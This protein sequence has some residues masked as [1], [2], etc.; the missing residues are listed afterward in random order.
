MQ[1]PI[2]G[3]VGG[4]GRIG[5][6]ESLWRTVGDLTNGDPWKFSK[7]TSGGCLHSWQV[8][9]ASPPSLCSSKPE[10]CWESHVTDKEEVD[11]HLRSVPPMEWGRKWPR[12]CIR[13]EAWGLAVQ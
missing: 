1:V 4:V 2:K 3:Y 8:E 6:W 5:V 7:T 10:T 9:V 13:N 12:K 11:V